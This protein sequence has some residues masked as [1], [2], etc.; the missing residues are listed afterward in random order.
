MTSYVI[1]TLAGVALM[2]TPF[3]WCRL[4]G[5]EPEDYGISWKLEKKSFA[6]LLMIT[7]AVLLPLTIVSMNWPFESLPRHSTLWRSLN[8]MAAGM[9]AAIIEEIFYRGWL[10]PLFKK[11]VGAFW[12]IA[13]SSAL[14]ALSHI[15]VAQ[16]V[17]LFAVFFPGCVMGFL[18]ERHGNIS[19]STIFH[20]VANV[21]A[22]W[23]APLHWPTMPWI[24]ERL[25]Q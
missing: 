3:L 15:F 24:I 5:E 11:R 10:Q 13:L 17:F 23:F 8:L 2:G 14:F 12:A 20:A 1:P 22:V 19:T 6:E 7:A 18:R 25:G 21:W 16:T 4:R 9:S